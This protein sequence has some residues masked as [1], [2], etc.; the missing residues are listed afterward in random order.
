[1]TEHIIRWDHPPHHPKDWVTDLPGVGRYHVKRVAHRHY[2][3]ASFSG[4]PTAF[5]GSTADEVKAMCER[6]I[7]AFEVTSKRGRS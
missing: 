5:S 6:T 4:R 1:M 3:T 7:R 2:W